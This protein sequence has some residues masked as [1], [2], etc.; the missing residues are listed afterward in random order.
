LVALSIPST[1]AGNPLL[2]SLQ[3]LVD[4][5][6]LDEHDLDDIP[7]NSTKVDFPVVHSTKSDHLLLAADRWRRRG[8]RSRYLRSWWRNVG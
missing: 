1:F 8:R 7:S 4:Q 3:D 5:G 6:W 2:I